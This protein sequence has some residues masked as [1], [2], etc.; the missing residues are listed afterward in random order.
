MRRATER[1]LCRAG[2]TV[3]TAADGEEAL[4]L[5]C[6]V[7]PDVILL[8]MLLPKVSGLDVLRALRRNPITKKT[9]IVVMSGLSQA[10]EMKLRNEGADAYFQKSALDLDIDGGSI[11]QVV[12]EMLMKDGDRK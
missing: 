8:D 4:N 9:P 6:A 2:Y 5:A 3:I 7:R 12:E 10:N 1:V 11:V